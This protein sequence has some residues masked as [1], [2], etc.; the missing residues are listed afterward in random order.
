MEIMK[1]YKVEVDGKNEILSAGAYHLACNL[2]NI[3]SDNFKLI[4]YVEVL[5]SN[6]FENLIHRI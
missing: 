6:D 2:R 1:C 3:N 4:E 5:N